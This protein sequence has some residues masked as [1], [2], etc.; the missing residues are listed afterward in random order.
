[1]TRRR[2]TRL[3]APSG[4][5]VL[6]LLAVVAVVAACSA[7]PAGDTPGTSSS[8]GTAGPS[9][10]VQPSRSAEV[11]EPIDVGG[12]RT[13][14][15]ECHGT[16]SPTVIL[17]SG[18][19][20]AA[21]IWQE[22]DAYPP[23]VAAG[24]ASFTRVCSYD[25]PG[26]YVVTVEQNGSRVQATSPDQYKP[27]RGNAV[28]STTAGGGAQV[29]AGLRQ[30]LAVAGVAPPY[31]LV[32]H[33]LGGLFSQLYAR[34]Y[35]NQVSG[36]VLVDPPTPNLRDFLSPSAWAG[37]FESQLDPGPSVIP[38]YVNE[39]YRVETIFDEINAAG[40]LP[41]IPVTYLAATIKPSLDQLPPADQARALEIVTQLPVAAASYIHTI[42]GARFVPVPDTTHYI[43]T[44]RPDVVIAAAQ[45]AAANRTLTITP[46]AP[47]APT[48]P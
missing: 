12:G 4:V 11:A 39:R 34:A 38:G 24:V 46:S 5:A 32:G 23:S 30:L 20:N 14:Y 22:A 37:A 28:A 2:S 6:G 29:V 31:V 8:A 43:Q 19:G 45:A 35:P 18:F 1:M 25:R 10:G 48:T 42:P 27:A 3:S 9:T 41:G 26:S 15:L 47:T 21:D 44:E 7:T 33:S 13:I 17:L 16:G 36:M 40:P